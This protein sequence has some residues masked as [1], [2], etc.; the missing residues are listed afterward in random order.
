MLETLVVPIESEHL[1]AILYILLFYSK[2]TVL[3]FLQLGF[4]SPLK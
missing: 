3:L 4:F 1:D 2:Q